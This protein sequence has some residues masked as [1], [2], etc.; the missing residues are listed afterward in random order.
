MSC[1]CTHAQFKLA[2]DFLC[3]AGHPLTSP[4]RPHRTSRPKPSAWAMWR[5]SSTSL[6]GAWAWPCWWPSSSSAIS[7]ATRPREWRWRPRPNTNTTINH[8]HHHHHCHSC[9]TDSPCPSPKPSQSQSPPHSPSPSIHN[10]AEFSEGFSTYG[11]D[12]E[13]DK[14]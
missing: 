8:Q 2:P 14:M 9:P 5:G 10:L 1:E 13:V 3:L 7:H 12:G 4:T 6:W 11:G